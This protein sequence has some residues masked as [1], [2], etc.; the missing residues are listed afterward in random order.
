MF[1]NS[2]SMKPSYMMI[3]GVESEDKGSLQDATEEQT[4]SF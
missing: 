2:K 3:Q 4:K 1:S